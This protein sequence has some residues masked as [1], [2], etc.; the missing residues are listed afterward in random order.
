MLVRRRMLVLL[1]RRTVRH[2]WKSTQRKVEYYASHKGCV[3]HNSLIPT[4]V[5]G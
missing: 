3:R 5:T 4:I 1:V 2:T